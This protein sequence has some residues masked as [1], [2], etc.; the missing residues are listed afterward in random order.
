LRASLDEAMRLS[1]PSSTLPRKV[2]SGGICIDGHFFPED[3]VVDVNY[4]SIHHVPKYYPKQ[5][6]YNPSRWI[7]DPESGVTQDSVD[8]ARSAFYPFSIS[9]RACIARN[10]AY[11][12]LTIILARII[13]MHEIRISLSSM[14]GEGGASKAVYGRHRKEEYQLSDWMTMV[15]DGP[16]IEFKLASRAVD[17]KM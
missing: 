11:V 1:P 12:E 15:K 17:E 14:L 13:Y 9:P 4:Y 5:F 8:L 2:L 10:I 6:V 3:T 7:V 16:M